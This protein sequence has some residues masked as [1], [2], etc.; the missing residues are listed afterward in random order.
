MQLLETTPWGATFP[1]GFLSLSP[2]T[3]ASFPTTAFGVL[4]PLK[5]IKR[6]HFIKGHADILASVTDKH[7]NRILNSH[8]LN[9]TIFEEVPIS[10]WA[11]KFGI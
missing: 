10:F 11:E 5:N 8:I 6:Q 4:F 2:H 1:T 7:K 3:H 9:K